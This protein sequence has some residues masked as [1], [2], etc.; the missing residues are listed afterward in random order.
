MIAVSMTVLMFVA[1]AFGGWVLEGVVRLVRWHRVG[2][3]GFLTG[4]VLPIYA[5]GAVGILAFTRPIRDDPAL[6]FLTGM[7]IAS[8]VEFIGH[9]LLEKMMGLVL[10]DY[11]GRL[12]NIQG[13]VCLGNSLGFGVAGLVVV[14]VID[15]ALEAFLSGLD[16]LVV[17]SLASGLGAVMV[18]DW[19]HA[20]VAVVRVRPEIES[21]RGSL[22]EVRAQLERQLDE[23]GAD[24]QNGVTR[25][26]IRML[27]GSRAVLTRLDATFPG[28]RGANAV[29]G[30]QASVPPHEAIADDAGVGST[31]HVAP[32]R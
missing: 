6:V 24:F 11:S 14:E 1:Y 7:L 26:R 4:P 8:V 18:V 29:R 27:R 5:F 2:N 25:R 30:A 3:H 19:V 31:R 21:I 9:V 17:V 23:L 15:P 20:V 22:D 10:W 12:G 28:A 13:R 32:I 16:P